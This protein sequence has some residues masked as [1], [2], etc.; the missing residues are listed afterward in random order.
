MKNFIGYL[1]VFL[2]ILFIGINVDANSISS[3]KMDIY[4][5]SYGNAHVK[6]VWD[7]YL[8]EGTEGYRSYTNL[9]GASISNFRVSDNTTDYQTLSYWNTNASFNS[10]AYKSGINYISDGVELC[11]GISRYGRNKYTLSYTINGFV[12]ETND[13]DLV[14]WQ[15]INEDLASLTDN[16]YIKIYSDFRYSDTLGVW[17]YGNYGGYAYVYDGYIEISNNSLDSDEYMVALI[18]FPKD[19]FKTS[20][21]KGN[22]FNYYKE[23]AE[24]G[25]L[26][27]KQSIWET[28]LSIIMMF[29]EFI[30]V[31]VIIIISSIFASKNTNSGSYKLSFGETG[32]KLPRDVNMFRDIPCNK[33]IF[34]AYWVAYNYNLMK[35]QTDFLGAILLKWLKQK[36]IEIKS[37]EK[38][39]FKKE[40]TSIVFVNGNGFDTPLETTLYDYMYKASHDGILESREFEKWCKNNYK[41]ILDWFGKVLDYESRELMQEGMLTKTTKKVLFFDTT[42]YEVNPRMMDE[43]IKMKGLKEFF[44]YFKN[45]DD[46]EAIEVMLWEEY[47]MY[48]QLFG[49]A[50]EVA[51]QFKKL[52]PDVITDYDYE[53]VIFVRNV[54]YSGI[55][56]ANTAKQRAQSYSSG[57]GGFSSGGGGGGSFGGGGGGFR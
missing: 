42:I 32:K 23:L 30:F 7:S 47:L 17:G 39:I 50:D 34:R 1:G 20:N 36:H 22:D 28:I 18:K 2:F 16:V 13:S 26:A 11:F 33:D 3:I 9:D 40:E 43:A 35:K 6:E 4:I 54:S 55:R 25:S 38:G 14:Y 44:N 29:S 5:D 31:F 10:K 52:Y 51:K 45:M 15:F 12:F 41:K 56:S 21:I 53:S 8:E 57:G 46:K 24:D 27:Y 37:N 19:T 49:V 48:A